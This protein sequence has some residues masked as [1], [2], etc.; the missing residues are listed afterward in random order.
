[1]SASHRL[2]PLEA[3]QEFQYP[4][5]KLGS[6]V[7]LVTLSNLQKLTKGV[8]AIQLVTVPRPSG[9]NVWKAALQIT[10][11]LDLW[12]N[13][14]MF[15]LRKGQSRERVWRETQREKEGGGGGG[16]ERERERWADLAAVNARG[17]IK[18]IGSLLRWMPCQMR[19]C[20]RQ[21]TVTGWDIKQIWDATCTSGSST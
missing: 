10:A 1:M 16:E 19:L 17:F 21:Y 4:A 12:L 2:G 9:S 11:L 14:S 3:L 13:H 20:R 18:K 6:N 8:R 15:S 5:N 7:S